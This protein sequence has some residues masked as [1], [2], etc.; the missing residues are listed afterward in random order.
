MAAAAQQ[1][2]HAGV[3]GMNP[4]LETLGRLIREQPEPATLAEALAP[5]AA[6]RDEHGQPKVTLAQLDVAFTDSEGRRCYVDVSVTSAGTT[7]AQ[8][9]TKRAGEDGAAAADM[10]RTKR[11][12]YPAAKSPNTPMIPFVVEALGRLSPEAQGLLSSIAPPDKELRSVVLRRAKQSV[13]VLVQ[14]RLADLLLS[15]EAGRAGALPAR[16]SAA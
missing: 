3:H 10:V 2:Q 1:A 12:K 4:W 8:N 11:S 16:A 5:L 7:S 14:T 9:R 15:A 6:L 13:S